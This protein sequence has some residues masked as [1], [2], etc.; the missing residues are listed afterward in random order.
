MRFF[1]RPTLLSADIAILT[2]LHSALK[3]EKVVKIGLR[4]TFKWPTALQA[5]QSTISVLEKGLDKL[6]IVTYDAD[7]ASRERQEEDTTNQRTSSSASSATYQETTAIHGGCT[8]LPIKSSASDARQPPTWSSRNHSAI[9]LQRSATTSKQL[10]RCKA[11]RQ[12]HFS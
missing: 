8:E 4:S 10:D 5:V 1:G 6:R 11:I 7:N 2:W 3:Q 9:H 12:S